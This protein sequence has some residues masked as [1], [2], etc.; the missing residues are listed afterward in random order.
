[1]LVVADKVDFGSVSVQTLQIASLTCG[2]DPA[3][4]TLSSE[5]TK[6]RSS[7]RQ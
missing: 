2:N 4:G 6:K 7:P 5:K 1:L 3:E